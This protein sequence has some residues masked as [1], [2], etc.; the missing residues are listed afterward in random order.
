MPI[1]LYYAPKTR[2]GRVRWLLEE[3]AT[4]YELVAVD[5][6]GG[7][8]DGSEYRAIHPLGKVPAIADGEQ[9]VFESAAIC[10]H[11]A[12]RFPEKNLAPA[13]GTPER[14]L[15][16]QWIVYGV[17]TVEPAAMATFFAADDEAKATAAAALGE[18]VGVVGQAIERG[19]PFLLGEQFSAADVLVG[20]GLLWGRDMGW[21]DGQPALAE[22]ADRLAERPAYKASLA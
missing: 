7:E 4:P 18:V 17:A 20:S 12:D 16:Y 10:L 3:L 15:Y 22:Y 9:V 5:R 6:E 21:L 13:L 19:G 1:R 2:A 11:L 8:C 14:G